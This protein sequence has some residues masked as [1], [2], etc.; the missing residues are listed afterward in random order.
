MRFIY[1]LVQH[2]TLAIRLKHN[3]DGM[4]TQIPAAVALAGLYVTL[5]L[6]NQKAHQTISLETIIGLAFI[7]QCY[8]FSL[9]NKVIG[10]I[11]LIGI[12]TNT[13]TIILTVFT[14]IAEHQLY[15][16]SL[17]EYIMVF[18]SIINVIKSNLKVY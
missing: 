10:L 5:T 17:L 16:I 2:A 18:F 4:P 9:R 15:I 13:A 14:N 6:V 1:A 7:S 11:L 12:I 3:G 8:I